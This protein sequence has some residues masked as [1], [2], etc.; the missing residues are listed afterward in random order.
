MDMITV[1]DRI[2]QAKNRYESISVIHYALT[3]WEP[4]VSKAIIESHLVDCKYS[5][6][7][8]FIAL[9]LIPDEGE[10]EML[11]RN[12]NL[13][14]ITDTEL[15]FLSYGMRNILRL[16]NPVA[17]IVMPDNLNLKI[18]QIFT[19]FDKFDKIELIKKCNLD[20]ST[21]SGLIGLALL[22]D[23]EICLGTILDKVFRHPNFDDYIRFCFAFEKNAQHAEF[24]KFI[25]KIVSE[26]GGKEFAISQK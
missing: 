21:I 26:L 13:N 7:A 1:I 2:K 10:P 3:H 9:A 20:R 16:C 17:S 5:T 14:K 6:N 22:P 12:M 11:L 8:Q 24:E 4:S 25:N 18:I 15:I 19:T 23:T